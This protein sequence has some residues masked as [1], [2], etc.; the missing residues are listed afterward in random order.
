MFID[1][2]KNVRSKILKCI[3]LPSDND[4]VIYDDKFS[5]FIDKDVEQL[6]KNY[7]EEYKKVESECMDLSNRIKQYEDFIDNATIVNNSFSEKE[8]INIIKN[9]ET[10]YAKKYKNIK[11]LE[12]QIAVYQNRLTELNKKLDYQKIVDRNF[13]EKE[14]AKLTEEIKKTELSIGRTQAYYEFYNDLS[15]QY[16][17]IIE[18]MKKEKVFYEDTLEK[19]MAD[20]SLCYECKRRYYPSPESL[21]KIISKYDRSIEEDN[22]KYLEA[23]EK[24][25]NY[26]KEKVN[27]NKELARLKEELKMYD[28]IYVKKSDNIL[29]IEKAKFK[30][31]NQIDDLS[32][33]LKQITSIQT[34]EYFNL[35]KEIDVFKTSLFNLSEKKRLSKELIELKDIYD[36]TKSNF[37]MIKGKLDLI[38]EFLDMKF[39][40]YEKNI[41]TLFA[42]RVK[43][44]LFEFKFYEIEKV[45]KIKY[46]NIDI[47]YL[48][49][50]NYVELNKLIVK[51]L[52][53]LEVKDDN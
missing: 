29:K 25:A 11:D 6:Y 43:F 26:K 30:V 41:S 27:L 21:K 5:S 15:K 44:K 20:T 18:I 38:I 8:Y 7:L 17:T 35:K 51:K 46:N 48:N 36:K 45:M 49:A 14:K 10:N 16:L 32:N 9:L 47:D 28:T 3:P 33:K 1:D 53:S 31:F 23:K 2:L 37:D 4:I 39:K 42:N 13:A 34:K 40:V 24:R 22:N 52:K 19:S 50:D 12:R